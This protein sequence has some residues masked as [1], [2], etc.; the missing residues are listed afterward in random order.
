MRRARGG[1]CRPGIWYIWHRTR[2]THAP[3]P[4]RWW[5][6]KRKIPVRRAPGRMGPHGGWGRMVPHAP[7]GRRHGV[8]LLGP[9]YRGQALVA[10]KKRIWLGRWSLGRLSASG[11]RPTHAT[12]TRGTGAGADICLAGDSPTGALKPVMC[13]WSSAVQRAFLVLGTSLYLVRWQWHL[14]ETTLLRRDF[15]PHL[16]QGPSATT[17]GVV[18]STCYLDCT[19]RHALPVARARGLRAAWRLGAMCAQSS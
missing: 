14:Q 16:L 2:Y 13:M 1:G 9:R 15:S 11:L 7:W 8:E 10:A 3:M 12:C 4:T 6:S 5:G 18:L 19:P 17:T